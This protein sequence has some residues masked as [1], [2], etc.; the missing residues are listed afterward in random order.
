MTTVLIAVF[1]WNIAEE[2]RQRSDALTATQLALA[3]EQQLSALGGQA[4]ATA[5]LLGSPLATISIIAREL[6]RELP[7]GSP[8]V[9][10]VTEMVA[11]TQRCR[12]LLR[13]LSRRSDSRE[14]SPSRACR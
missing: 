4:A 12:E 1:V 6:Q 13:G 14:L 3:R 2:A 10:E 11:Q 5:H 7:V 8:L 9:E